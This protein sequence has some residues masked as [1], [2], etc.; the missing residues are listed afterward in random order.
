MSKEQT[1][2]WT[3][4]QVQGLPDCEDSS[5]VICY[6]SVRKM[7]QGEIKE[8]TI[9][10]TSEEERL[11]QGGFRSVPDFTQ[12]SE[13]FN[14][15][16]VEPWAWNTI[17][18]GL[19]MSY[20][21]Y[22]FF[23]DSRLYKIQALAAM[24]TYFREVFNTYPYIDYYSPEVNCG[25]STA[26]KALVWSSYY[27][28]LMTT[29]TP[30][31]IYRDID[32]SKCTLG[33]D[34]IDNAMTNKDLRGLLLSVL[35]SGY[36]KGIPAK[37]CDPITQ[38]VIR[39]D[40][41]GLKAFTRVKGLDRAIESRSITFNMIRNPAGRILEELTS[42]FIFREYRDQMYRAR[43]E[44]FEDV[45]LA[46]ETVLNTVGLQNRSRQLFAPLLTM[47]QLVSAEVFIETLAFAKENAEQREGESDD[48]EAKALIEI[49]LRT[50]YIGHEV[51]VVN[52]CTDLNALLHEREIT[53]S[54]FDFRSKKVISMLKAVGLK[55]GKQSQNRVHYFINKDIVQSWGRLYGLIE[56]VIQE[57][58]GEVSPTLTSL[59]TLTILTKNE[60][61][62][63][64]SEDSE[65]KIHGGDIPEIEA[66]IERTPKEWC[67]TVLK[68]F[69]PDLA[70]N[71]QELSLGDI[72]E[73]FSTNEYSEV[74]EALF[75]LLEEGLLIE[76]TSGLY[77][78][79]V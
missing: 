66:I 52:L 68:L 37:R 13:G 43:L 24:S 78:R 46:Y 74:D 55:R 3:L 65:G 20:M 41:F 29:P 36:M 39:F 49:L 26:M 58:L 48:P 59:T 9:E 76:L 21:R 70:N 6:R 15:G 47:A 27:G 38:K 61:S 33:I 45:A 67:H 11:S 30:A 32:E 63:E 79:V 18:E 2:T 77:R 17:Y 19:V 25:K 69:D 73:E 40:A 56:P 62:G 75:T 60:E 51:P 22:V 57:S 31:V 12:P 5:E 44:Q 53:S 4:A 1:P 34:E 64:G 16:G 35:N 72:R 50:E 14:N 8:F 28:D 23:P 10:Y 71:G 54:D 42:P 7:Y